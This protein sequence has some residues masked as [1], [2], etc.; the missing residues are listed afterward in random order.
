MS[1]KERKPIVFNNR[2][3]DKGQLK[4]LIV[5]S[6]RHYGTA[7][8]AQMADKLKELGFRFATRAGVSISIDDLKIPPIKREMLE[9]AENTIDETEAKYTRGEITEVERFQKV[10]DTWNTTSESLYDG[11]FGGAGKLIPSASARGDARF[12]GQSARGNHRF[13][14]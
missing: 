5:W 3:V 2:M 10:I 12:D 11:V 13:T 4:K 14:D 6:F 9:A 8:T 1:E 7:R